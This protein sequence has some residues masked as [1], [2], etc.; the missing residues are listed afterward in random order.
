M[1]RRLRDLLIFSF[2]LLLVSEGAL[3]ARAK[4]CGPP[5]RAKPQRRT[6]GESFPPLPL[7]ATPLRRTEKKRPPAPPALIGKVQYG[8]IVWQTDPKT[9]K[10]FSYRD[11]TTDPGDIQT[12]MR[13][14]NSALGIRYR[15]IHT[16]FETFSYNPAE[17][18]ILYLTGHEAFSLDE[19]QRQKL[20]LFVNDG[21]YLIGDAC[22]GSEEFFK[23]FIAEMRQTFPDRPL[24]PLAADH[25]LYTCH[26][27]IQAVELIEEGKS[28]GRSLPPIFGINIGCRTAVFAWP[29]DLSC[30]WDGHT[31]PHGKRVAIADARR[32][33]VNLM[34]YC[35][36]NYQLGRFLSTQRIYHQAE[37][38]TRDEFVFAQVVHE[39]DW[40]PCPNGVMNFLRYARA[41]STLPVQFKR[42]AV[43]L[44]DPDILR[45]PVLYITG[46]FDFRL[47]DAEVAGL[48]NYLR[49]G[50]ILI[51]SACCGRK[52]FDLAFRREIARALP[53]DTA[54]E[55]LPLDHP[56]YSTHNRVQAVTYSPMLLAQRKELS[57]PVL[58]GATL[59]GRL[60]VLYSRFGLSTE[61]DGQPRPFALCYE[62]EDALRL[63]LNAV[64]YAM[65]H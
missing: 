8:K 39:G 41:N 46:H 59:D 29:Y 36:A 48:R 55:L 49:N 40:D 17:I 45:Y 25:P 52:A 32:L 54:L 64:I 21:G 43:K 13:F 60:C 38:P 31:H 19:D 37:E 24:R 57:V 61:W 28:V 4:S 14:T 62:T 16:T 56:L 1:R 42:V 63:G 5:P 11:W 50:G 27:R 30:G 33:G 53:K 35:L 51:G 12:L 47:D 20:R 10:R 9:G 58:E 3:V 26:Y 2:A 23:S 15:P 7:P 65:T 34:S 18:P 22:C 44:S 6:G